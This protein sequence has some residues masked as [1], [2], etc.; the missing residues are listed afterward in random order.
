M[1]VY[2]FCFLKSFTHVTYVVSLSLSF[3]D[4]RTKV[5]SRA[6]SSFLSEAPFFLAGTRP[7]FCAEKDARIISYEPILNARASLS[8]SL[9]FFLFLSLP[10]HRR[11]LLLR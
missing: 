9:S 8:F 7:F 1:R 5:L 10:L 2:L 4:L 6:L 3:F 11:H